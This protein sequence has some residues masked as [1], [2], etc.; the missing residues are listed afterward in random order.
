MDNE[1]LLELLTAEIRQLREDI[2]SVRHENENNVL[3]LREDIA[4]VQLEIENNIR[5]DIKLLAEGQELILERMPELSE[6]NALKDRLKIVE[7]ILKQHSADI[8]NLRKAN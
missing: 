1:K 7:S 5:R 3:Q 2:T 8:N 4:S 6:V